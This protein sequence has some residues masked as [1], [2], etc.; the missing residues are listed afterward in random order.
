VTDLEHLETLLTKENFVAWLQAQS[1]N[2][3]VGFARIDSQCPLACYLSDQDCYDPSVNADSIKA[4]YL[5][6][7]TPSWATQFVA[8]VDALCFNTAVSKLM[9]LRYLKENENGYL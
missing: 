9:A 7:D 1:D 6:I 5:C 8:R 2:T 4:N 3:V